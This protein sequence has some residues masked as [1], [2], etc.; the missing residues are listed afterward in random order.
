MATTT[1]TDAA[2]IDLWLAGRP[3]ATKV[4]YARDVELFQAAVGKPLPEV[5]GEDAARFAAGLLGSKATQARR[6][7]S[8]KSLFG[9][10]VRLGLLPANP[11]LV[12][13]CPRAEG[14][15]HERMLTE[16]EVSLV[17][18]EASPGRD[19]ALVRTLYLGGLRITEALGI[20]FSDLGKRWLT[21]RGKG[22]RTRTVVIPVGLI[23]ELRLLRWKADADDA[24]VFKGKSGAAISGRYARRMIRVASEEAIGR[25]IGPHWLRHSHAT[26]A[27][28]RGAPIHLVQNSLG[29]RSL[30]TTAAYLHVRPNQGSSQYL[31]VGT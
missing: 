15:A 31:A 1:K 23:D 24:H 27:L 9:F 8:I 19:R 16:E 30:A 28:E 26:H 3:P 25:P 2:L 18:Q 11:T 7:A 17:I 12:I 4:A 14:A 21:V 20:R 22:S 13:R 5:Q 10:G 29:H 6:I